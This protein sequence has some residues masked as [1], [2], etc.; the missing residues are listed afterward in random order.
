MTIVERDRLRARRMLHYTDRSV[1]EAAK[2]AERERRGRVM[3]NETGAL[4]PRSGTFANAV[5]DTGWNG[6]PQGIPNNRYPNRD[7]HP[8]YAEK[9]RSEHGTGQ[10]VQQASLSPII[11]PTRAN[12]I[13]GRAEGSVPLGIGIRIWEDG[14]D[15]VVVRRK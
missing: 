12:N 8:R 7:K 15:D 2:A 14:H 6:V 1:A 5:K 4:A 9:P 13:G 3:R 11:V 10:E